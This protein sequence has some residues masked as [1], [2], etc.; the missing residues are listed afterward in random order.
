MTDFFISYS[1][2]DRAWAEWIAWI[3]EEAG[4]KARIHVWDLRPGGNFAVEMQRAAVDSDRT[5]AVLSPDYLRSL[6][7]MAEWTAAFAAD[8]D[9]SQGKLVPVLVRE[10]EPGSLGLL[11]AILQI[12]LVGLGES[13]AREELLKGLVPGRVRPESVRFPGA[14]LFPGRAAEP[15]DPKAAREA[16]AALPLEEIPQPGPLPVGS[17]MPLAPNPLFV[18]REEALKT[19]A[20]Q[21]KAGGTSAVGQVEIAAAT[22][23]GGMGKT[24]LASEFVHRYGRYFAGGVFWMSFADGSTVPIEVAA[25]GQSLGLQVGFDT[26]ALEQQ[27]RHVEEAWQ[28]PLPRLLVFDNCEEEELLQRWRP[29]FGGARVLVTSRRPDWDAT[30]NVKTVPIT[31]LPRPASIEL[32]RG[33]RPDVP[34]DDPALDAIANE[35]GD[36]PLALHLAGSFLQSYRN[37]SFGV[38]A[39]YLE[40]L[41]EKD[42]L[43]HPS[44]RGRGAGTSPTG[45]E[46]HVGRTFALSLDRLDPAS[47]SDVL[48]LKLLVRAAW[49]AAGEPISRPL[50][51]QSAEIDSS[52]MEAVLDGEDALG[53]LVDLGILEVD[54]RGNPLMHRLVAAWARGV[55]EADLGRVTVE[56]MMITEATRLNESRNPAPLRPWQAHLR[57]VTERAS[58]RQD[59]VAARLC[60]EMGLHLWQEGD[61]A[62]GRPYLERAVAVQEAVSGPEHPATARSLNSLGRILI[63]QGD[64]PAARSALERSLRIREITPGPEHPDTAHSLNDLGWLLGEQGNFVGARA[65][66]ERALAIREKVLG[67]HHQDTGQSLHNL[68]GLLEEQGDPA[69]ARVYYERA[70][71]IW[72]KVLGPDHPDTAFSLNNLGWLLSQQGDV[73]GARAYYER[74]LSIREKILGSDHPDTARSL[75]NLGGLHFQQRNPAKARGFLERAA[76]ILKAR[77]GPDH[78]DTKE[79]L[80]GLSQLPGA[81]QMKKRPSKKKR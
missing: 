73:A 81:R 40:S 3:L 80:W 5:I 27:V 53:R 35:L 21:L 48:A 77:L 55:A 57:F 23:L 41:R 78:P 2:L 68:G 42:L 15:P 74:A 60:E 71:A 39:A 1:Q 16:L 29:R 63:D 51:L 62:G 28:S 61:Y 75:L 19:L 59:G 7:G 14:H 69:G 38:P 20:S 56:E 8:P 79:A 47:T 32:L 10:V 31:T 24:Q 66:F 30:L 65:Y 36:L 12:R 9:G 45:H 52:D 6:Y 54:D 49:F 67:P 17:R 34:K 4:H 46:A 11:R 72:E 64:Y 70:L 33:F 26:L 13:A 18:G 50:L 76:R 43:A 37:S 58:G 22:G 25:S 44:L